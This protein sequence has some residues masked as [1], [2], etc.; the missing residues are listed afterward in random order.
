MKLLEAAVW[1]SV[2]FATTYAFS[3]R[4]GADSDEILSANFP[5]LDLQDV[6]VRLKQTSRD[7]LDTKKATIINIGAADR[8]QDP[9]YSLQNENIFPNG[10]RIIGY[11]C[12]QP[13]A[14]LLKKNH[15]AVLVRPICVTRKNIIHD[16]KSH[17]VPKS[18]PVLKIDIDSTD[19]TIMDTIL[20]EYSP[21]V[22]YA[23]IAWDFPPPIDFAM[24]PGGV[25][26]ESSSSASFSGEY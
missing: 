13:S 3:I 14:K 9:I 25:L 5:F 17:K 23:E 7:I 20:S 10:Y 18:F 1:A 21:L 12:H 4:K 2:W 6:L 15:P 8:N 19:A 24:A 11:E 22:I 26:D 16:M